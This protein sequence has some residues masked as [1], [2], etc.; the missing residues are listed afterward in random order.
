MKTNNAGFEHKT[1][2]QF[3]SFRFSSKG[4]IGPLSS[5]FMQKEW[6]NY[7]TDI[8]PQQTEKSFYSQT[9]DSEN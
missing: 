4:T 7:I 6:V 8:L 2:L 5:S 3:K 1:K 9:N